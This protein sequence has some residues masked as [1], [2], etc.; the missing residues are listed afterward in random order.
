MLQYT[1]PTIYRKVKAFSSGSINQDEREYLIT[2]HLPK[3]KYIAD[4]IAAKLPPS[5]ERDDL[6]G[7]G[8]VGLI[9]AVERYDASRGIA[10][11]TFAEM[12]VRGAILD[13]LRS[14]DWAS[15]STRRR[16]REVQTAYS[17]IEQE[18]GRPANEEEVAER[19]K[20]P[21]S[22]LHETL[23]DI[24][25]LC[26]TTLDD[27]DEETGLSVSEMIAD[28]SVSPLDQLEQSQR[29]RLLADSIDKLPDRE[30]QV[31]ALYYLEELT[32]K[33]IGEVLGVTESRVSQ[34]R[35]QAVL[36]LRNNLHG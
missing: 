4:R 14:L 16:A 10:F 26:V 6:Y 1:A 29:R 13:N 7:A 11:T 24:R 8:V 22:E 35:T 12:R 5:V 17:Q 21:L 36:R 3:V 23:Q 20:M 19:L 2:S 9:D 34:L 28:K 15:R 30:R 33:E 18:K 31:I 32:M 25:G 27:R